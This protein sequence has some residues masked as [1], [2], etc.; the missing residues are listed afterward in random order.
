M[1]T[2][3]T[4]FYGILAES[5]EKL[6]SYC[7]LNTPTDLLYVWYTQCNFILLLCINFE[8]NEYRTR[9]SLRSTSKFY[10]C[11]RR[12]AEVRHSNC[13]RAISSNVFITSCHAVCVQAAAAADTPIYSGND[14][15]IM[16]HCGPLLSL[17]NLEER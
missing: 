14:L 7:T 1:G 2:V 5:K 3:G 13:Q 9:A 6:V 12:L 11:R 8:E 4:D 10:Y 15:L 16:P 17:S